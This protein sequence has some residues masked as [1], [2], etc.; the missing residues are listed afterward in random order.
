MDFLIPGQTKNF[1]C[2]THVRIRPEVV[3][4][5]FAKHFL[6][7]KLDAFVDYAILH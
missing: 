2:D 7:H 5:D 6:V 1:V 3:G 4:V